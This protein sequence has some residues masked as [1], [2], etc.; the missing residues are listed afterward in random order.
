MQQMLI[1]KDE[2]LNEIQ[3]MLKRDQVGPV[4]AANQQPDGGN[5]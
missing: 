2:K 4:E 1:N 5:D 3:Q